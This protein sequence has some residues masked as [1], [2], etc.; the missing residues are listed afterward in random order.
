[1][2]FFRLIPI[3]L[4]TL[5]TSPLSAISNDFLPKIYVSSN[6]IGPYYEN[7]GDQYVTLDIRYNKFWL[8]QGVGDLDV[9]ISNEEIEEFNYFHVENITLM[10]VQSR[11]VDIKIPTDYYINHKAKVRIA[12]YITESIYI[13]ISFDIFSFEQETININD[14]IG[15][16]Y[17]PISSAI[18]LVDNEIVYFNEKIDFSLFLKDNISSSYHYLD[19]ER[20]LFKYPNGY[21]FSYKQAELTF[22]DR[23]GL[24]SSLDSK[25]RT[26]KSIPL[27]IISL[28]DE[29]YGFSYSS[30]YVRESD[31]A[32]SLTNEVYF[33]KTNK[34]YLPLNKQDEMFGFSFSIIMRDV[35][36]LHNDYHFSFE[37]YF[38]NNLIGECSNSEYCLSGGII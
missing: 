3:L 22:M 34:F 17:N 4:L 16:T 7:S 1:M 12:F 19:L 20:Y 30:L 38:D 23:T 35:G 2:I 14:L 21:D 15:Q 9:K 28:G 31:Y 37:Y 25:N 24:F 33:V 11:Y 5:F 6:Y 18:K 13:D 8:G 29:F 26:I 36:M 32:M 27:K 10:G